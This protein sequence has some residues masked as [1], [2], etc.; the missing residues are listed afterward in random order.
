MTEGCWIFW[1]RE[2]VILRTRAV[3]IVQAVGAR[4]CC[5]DQDCPWHVKR[6]APPHRLLVCFRDLTGIPQQNVAHGSRCR[7]PSN[8]PHRAKA[9]RSLSHS[10]LPG[11]MGASQSKARGT[12][13]HSPAEWRPE[14]ELPRG[15]GQGPHLQRAEH[16]TM[17]SRLRLP[18]LQPP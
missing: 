2:T 4:L 1:A 14:I 18:G 13:H 6:V 12:S 10:A 3:D 7:E 17:L 5:E 15:C 8:P 9:F 11:R 16:S